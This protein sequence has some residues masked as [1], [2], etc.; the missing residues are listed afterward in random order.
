MR[1]VIL[2]LM[3][4]F[5][6]FFF[7]GHLFELIALIPNWQSGEIAEV[8][9]YRDF[10]SKSGPGNYFSLTQGGTLLF[11]LIGLISVWKQGG[12]A[13]IAAAITLLVVIGVGF[14]TYFVFL[15]TNQYIGN[16]EYDAVLLKSLVTKWVTNE[17]FRFLAIGI[18]LAA[19]IWCFE[20]S[21]R[22]TE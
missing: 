6:A 13:K 20:A 2:W 9:R 11:S 18:G 3:V 16:T 4:L 12:Q 7:A 1:K 14:Y 8:A 5:F 19:S 22:K 15:P 21:R 17:P 10:L